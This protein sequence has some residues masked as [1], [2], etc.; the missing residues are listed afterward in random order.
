MAA[1]YWHTGKADDEAVFHLYF[2]KPPFGGGHA[3]ACG[4]TVAAQIASGFS[5]GDDDIAYLRSLEGSDQRPLFREDFLQRLTDF[6]FT[7]DIDCVREGEIVFANEPLVRVQAPLWQAQLIETT[8][9]TVVNFQT[10]VATK[11]ARICDAAGDD[12][13]FELGL[14]RA[15]GIGGGMDAS[16]ASYIGGCA[17]TSN[18]MAAKL[19][20]IPVKGTHAHSWVMSF[21]DELESFRAYA[22]AMPGNA[23]F[24]VDTYDTLE[25][26]RRAVQIGKDL[27]QQG[28]EMLGIRLDSGDLIA[29]SRAARQILDEACFPQAKIIA[30]NDLD[31][32]MIQKLKQGGA[33]IDIWGVGTKLVT[34]HDQPAL[35]GVYKLAAL[36]PQGANQWLPKA[37]HSEDAIKRS[38]PG[39]L[40]TRR[41]GN[42]AAPQGD[43]IYDTLHSLAE[44][45]IGRDLLIPAVRNGTLVATLPTATEARAYAITQRD[46]FRDVAMPYP[47]AISDNKINKV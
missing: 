30:S 8:L 7:G 9:L 19:F 37:K 45:P 42:P 32:Y 34:A 46:V 5:F 11:A 6:E 39:I 1:A 43:I 3:L 13:V 40:Q 27:R 22:A 21:D 23:T 26:V 44:L 4:T 33:R 10:L 16:R 31:E 38:I 17:G 24:L 15:Q 20:D 14:R 12:P 29:L 47:V 35:G 28:H 2:R 36:R 18:V 25:G 41:S